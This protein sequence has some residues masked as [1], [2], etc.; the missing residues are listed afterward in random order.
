MREELTQNAQAMS[1]VLSLEVV[2]LMVDNLIKDAR[3]L[4]PVRKVIERLEPALL[5]LVMVD[6]RF[7]ID[8]QHPARCLL[9][10]I[11]QRG[12][13]FGSVDDPD[14]NTFMLTLQR[15]VS[16]LAVMQ[17]DNAQPFDA[18]LNH[19]LHDWDDAGA[20]ATIASQIDSAAAV[21]GFAEQ[22]YLLAEQIGLRLKAIPDLA[23][24]PAAMVDFLLGP[25][26]QV[27][28]EAEL[29]DTTGADDAGGYKALVNELIWSAQ[30]VL[31][32]KDIARL[33]KLVPRLLS[34]LREGLGL[35]GYPSVK[36]S[37]FFDIL[38]KL[39]QQAFRPAAVDMAPVLP[40]ATGG[41]A[42]SLLA[43]QDQWVAPAE[44]KVSGFMAFADEAVPKAP[45][46]AAPEPAL[47]HPTSVTL[48]E[49]PELPPQAAA[50]SVGAWLELE[51]KGHWQRTQLSWISPHGTMYLFTSGQGK[52]QSMSQRML[53]RLLAAG[54]I[55]V[56]SDQVSMV[57]GAL[58]AV[59]HTAMLNSIDLNT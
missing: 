13:A 25:W 30:P 1:Q 39:H 38:M 29:K 48:A 53:A 18:A 2:S 33:T 24:V 51:I 54:K 31:T 52:T 50:L 22:R 42:P 47:S 15:Q 6:P 44:A 49:L 3:L 43:N 59:V 56:L 32:R 35:I 34:K 12:L 17:I 14:F 23:K 27:M 19:L 5:R 46:A 4:P 41:L 55:R 45:A 10:E 9:Q 16:P 11:A 28:A 36:T 40:G 58:D 57:D 8:R 20:R 37:A 26:S 21:L 7:F